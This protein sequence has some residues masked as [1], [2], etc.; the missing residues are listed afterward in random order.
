MEN[1]GKYKDIRLV[2]TDKR[3]KYLVSE[4]NH[5]TTK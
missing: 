4:P 2:T 5:H 3:R 1:V